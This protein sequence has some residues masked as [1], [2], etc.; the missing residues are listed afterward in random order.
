MTATE[1]EPDTVETT[2]VLLRQHAEQIRDM[3][4]RSSGEVGAALVKLGDELRTFGQRLAAE[5]Q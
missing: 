3:K 2:I 5:E 1:P 4:G